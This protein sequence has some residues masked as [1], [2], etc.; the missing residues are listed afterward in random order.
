MLNFLKNFLLFILVSSALIYFTGDKLPK[1]GNPSI[2]V[3]LKGTP[4][5]INMAEQADILII[6]SGLAE[7]ITPSIE[8]IGKKYANTFKGGLKVFNWARKNEG[9]HRTLYKWRTLKNKPLV[10]IYLGGDSEF[11]ES[12]FNVD[13]IE[14]IKDNI[15]RLKDPKISTLLSFLPQLGRFILKPMNTFV[16][17]AN[18][19]PTKDFPL[20]KLSGVK[21]LKYI[22]YNLKL[23]HHLMKKLMREVRISDKNIILIDHPYDVTTAPNRTCN[24]SKSETIVE[25]LFEIKELIKN[26]QTK[27]ALV[28]SR[29]LSEK[30]LGNAEVF[31]QRAV[32]EEKE[33][34]LKAAHQLY[35]LAKVFDCEQSTPTKITN[36]IIE[37]VAQEYGHPFI[38]FNKKVSLDFGKGPLFTDGFVPQEKYISAISQK[39]ESII[40]DTVSS[41]E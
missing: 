34:N 37:K 2:P 10:T 21:S 4:S 32:L 15:K 38:G 40:D 31:Y 23:Y 22:E 7:Y 12:K 33:K 13:D 28:L 3:S 17:Q 9:I 24:V 35:E 19:N 29:V 39:L 8:L 5:D 41:L 6:G 36:G 18:L 20:K 1:S 14:K 27:K 25:T 11:I 30:A 16:Y 26:G